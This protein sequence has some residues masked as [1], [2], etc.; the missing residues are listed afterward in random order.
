MERDWQQLEIGRD[1]I[2]I[3][4]PRVRTP[5]KSSLGSIPLTRERTVYQ[6][7]SQDAVQDR[8]GTLGDEFG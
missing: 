6:Q 1:I 8:E 4:T 5:L 2:D 3:E 7:R